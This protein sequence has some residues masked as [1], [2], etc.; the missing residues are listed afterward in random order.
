MKK[1]KKVSIFRVFKD[2]DK[3]LMI[4]SIVMFGFGLLN[5][6]TASSSEAVTRYNQD[7]LHYFNRQFIILILS[8]IPFIYIINTPTKK[9]K[10]YAI[11][12]FFAITSI[13]IYLLLYGVAH[14]GAIAWINILGFTFQPSEFAKPI[15]IVSLAII[16][17]MTRKIFKTGTK[18]SKTTAF[19]LV[20]FVG[21]FIPVLLFLQ[22]D[23]GTSVII[24][25]IFAIMFLVSPILRKDKLKFIAFLSGA[26]ITL[27]ILFS[28]ILPDGLL[29][30]AQSQ[31]FDF[32]DPCS[33]YETSGYQTCNAFIA[34][35]DGGIFGLGIGRSK[36]KYSY[37]SEPH[38]DS[39]FAIVAEEY[40]FIRSTLV[41]V[42]Y[43]I[44]LKRIFDISSKATNDKGR[45]MALGVGV[46]IFIHI[47]LNLGGLFAIMPL[48]G[49]PLPFLTYGGSYA[50][51]LCVALAIVQRVHIETKNQILKI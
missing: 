7:L 8:I 3:T 2:V 51:S 27:L 36:Q 25:F 50:I 6:A 28:L 47:F 23:L 41:F 13:L 19:G 24:V 10:N 18:E 42:G 32:I 46:Y 21:M 43:A 49:V 39:I 45:Y 4:V 33:K 30:D 34:I 1:K 38:T 29:T 37:L 17:E 5:I 40:G 20:L 26:G 44:I 48:T 22:K 15:I 31:R 14:K 12:A 11:V 9:F 16:F 35:N